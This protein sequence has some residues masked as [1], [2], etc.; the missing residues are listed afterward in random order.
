MV[1]DQTD[2]CSLV[3][4]LVGW[5]LFTVKGFET[6]RDNIYERAC[7][8]NS[9]HGNAVKGFW[10]FWDIYDFVFT[11]LDIPVILDRQFTS[12]YYKDLTQF[13]LVAL[14][15]YGTLYHT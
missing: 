10:T 12:Y 11:T 13:Q 6:L 9:C 1:P 15:Y 7:C 4:L 5:W 3:T 14:I 8:Y 2:K